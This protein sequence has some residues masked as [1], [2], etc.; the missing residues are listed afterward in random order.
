M[1][2]S[3]INIREKEFHNELQSRRKGRFENIFYKSLYNINE[4]FYSFLKNNAHNSS[5][6]DFGCGVGTFIEKV[7]KF[8]PKKI[9]GIDI[10]EVSVSKAQKR[11]KELKIV[12]SFKVDNCEKTSFENNSF[13]VVYG[14]GIIHHLEINKCIDEIHRILK[15]K[16]DLLFVEPLG[17]NPLINFYRILTPRSRSKDEHPLTDKDLDYIRNKFS[18]VN[19]KYYGFLTLLFSPFYKSPENSKLFKFIAKLDQKLFKIKLFRLFAWSIL[20]T[21]KKN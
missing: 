7:V 2:L 14:T 11:A 17:T 19:I 5:I 10:S 6:L 9:V 16:G 15:S 13:D 18:S 12:A 21:A 4:D 8:N 20:I 3:E 1:S